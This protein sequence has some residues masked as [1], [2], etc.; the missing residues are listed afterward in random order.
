VSGD[1]SANAAVARVATGNSGATGSTGCKVPSQNI[2]TVLPVGEA[3]VP[4]PGSFAAPTGLIAV[5][6][7][8]PPAGRKLPAPPPGSTLPFDPVFTSAVYANQAISGVDVRIYWADVEPLPGTFNWAIID[9]VFEAAADSQPAKFVVLT[10]VPGF[11]TPAW[12]L[13]NVAWAMFDRE[14]GAGA[15]KPGCLPVPW[16][17]A[18]E[19][20]W[21]DFLQAVATRYGSNQAFRMIDVDGPTSVS[22]EISLPDCPCHPSKTEKHGDGAL[23]P[24]YPPAASM[25]VA[26]N[27]S[28]I[29]MWKALGYTPQLYEQAWSTAFQEYAGIFP[30]QY[31]SLALHP[32]LPVPDAA[33]ADSVRQD[34]LALGLRYPRRLALEEAGLKASKTG[35]GGKRNVSGY[36][37]VGAN[38]GDLVTGY[39]LGTASTK[40]GSSEG[41]LPDVL[42][43]AVNQHA[44]FVE[45]YATDVEAATPGSQL[46]GV[47]QDDAGKLPARAGCTA[48]GLKLSAAPQTVPIGAPVMLTA[49]SSN[50]QF[51]ET[52][53]YINLY[54]PT[55]FLKQCEVG[56]TCAASVSLTSGSATYAA[57][58]GPAHAAPYGQQD[59]ASSTDTVKRATS[60]P[61]PPRC[62]GTACA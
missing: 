49:V 58:I 21:R 27:G 37:I 25:P 48:P 47:L 3:P 39:Q 54:G 57:D 32:G 8:A 56:T 35:S 61:G 44:D 5:E 19:M 51:N 1:G 50:L 53:D 33:D 28:D 17:Q 29:N 24:T 18:Y 43:A 23:P 12:A 38:C 45:V 60:K 41:S 2:A 22:P 40:T 52:P 11:G 4:G 6:Q 55:G 20:E 42:Q 31:V 46:E 26:I 7:Y 10:F 14:Y 15:G 62:K 59:I 13:G 30:K 34:I 9:Q 16:D 36:A